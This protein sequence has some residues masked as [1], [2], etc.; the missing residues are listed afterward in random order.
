M[1]IVMR[2]EQ[3]HSLLLNVKLAPKL[4]TVAKHLDTAIRLV[5]VTTADSAATHLLRVKTRSDRDALFDHIQRPLKITLP[6]SDGS[7]NHHHHHKE[8]ERKKIEKVLPSDS[9]NN[10]DN[11]KK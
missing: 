11:N 7:N 3:T 8:E 5:C 9:D 4:V 6:S 2:R 10:T 1:R